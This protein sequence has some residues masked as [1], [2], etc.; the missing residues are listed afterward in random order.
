MPFARSFLVAFFDA[1]QFLLS[2]GWFFSLKSLPLVTVNGA[3][4]VFRLSAIQVPLRCRRPDYTFSPACAL[5]ALCQRRF[6][7]RVPAGHDARFQ[8][9]DAVNEATERGE[10]G[11]RPPDGQLA[12][13][14]KRED[15]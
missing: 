15:A 5:S 8:Q 14:R 6:P 11:K 10:R 4:L 1:F 9:R 12:V 2:V 7:P 13:D 3:S